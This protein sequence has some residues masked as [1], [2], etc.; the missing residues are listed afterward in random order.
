MH[1]LAI[2]QALLDQVHRLAREE[3]AVAVTAIT[4]EVGPLSGVEPLLLTR[5][6]SLA[7]IS[8]LAEAAELIVKTSQVRVACDACGAETIATTNNLVCGECGNWQTRLVAGDELT[9]MRVEL[10]RKASLH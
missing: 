8:T 9:L 3:N 4:I 2:C 1:E 5:A 10:S 7:R 6:Y